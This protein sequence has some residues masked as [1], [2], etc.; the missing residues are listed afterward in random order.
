MSSILKEKLSW[1]LISCG[2]MKG[3][4]ESKMTLKFHAG[5]AGKQ[6]SH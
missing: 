4:D 1:L 2:G 6:W 3:A 5:V